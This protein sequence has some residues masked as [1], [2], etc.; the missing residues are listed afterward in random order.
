MEKFEAKQN[1]LKYPSLFSLFVEK[2]EIQLL[3][4]GAEILLIHYA[5][6]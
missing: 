3:V 6:K 2:K 1:H 4:T 5:V